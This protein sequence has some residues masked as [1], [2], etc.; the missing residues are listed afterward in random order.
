MA[1]L[2]LHEDVAPCHLL[3]AVSDRPL[4]QVV[5]GDIISLISDKADDKQ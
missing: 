2:N 1:K 4:K 5:R 3:F